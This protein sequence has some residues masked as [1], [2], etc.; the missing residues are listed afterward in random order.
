V[1]EPAAEKL[2]RVIKESERVQ[3]GV[4]MELLHHEQLNHMIQRNKLQIRFMKQPIASKKEDIQNIEQS[5]ISVAE[6]KATMMKEIDRIEKRREKTNDGAEDE[7]KIIANVMD[8]Y[9]NQLG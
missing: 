6:L 9:L 7:M 3:Q 8:L 1:S 2:A 4:D 5:L